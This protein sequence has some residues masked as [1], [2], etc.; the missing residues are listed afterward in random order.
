MRYLNIATVTLLLS[1]CA[2]PPIITSGKDPSD[3]TAAVSSTIYVPVN[4]DAARYAPVTP[5]SWKEQNAQVGPTEGEHDE[6]NQH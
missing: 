4:D 6:H 2:G 5:K 1:A 3:S